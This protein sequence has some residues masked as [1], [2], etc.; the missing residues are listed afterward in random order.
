MAAGN[1]YGLMWVVVAR[2]AIWL[3]GDK[4]VKYTLYA[5]V[6]VLV[7]TF[8]EAAAATTAIMGQSWGQWWLAGVGGG[9][10]ATTATAPVSGNAPSGVPVPTIAPLTGIGLDRVT[11]M[12]ANA[13]TWLGTPYH[14]G[15]CTRKGVD[16]SCFVMNVLATIGIQA[17]RVTTAQVRWVRP[18]TRAELQPG[19]LVFFNDTC[20][21]CGPNPTHVGMFIG[22]GKMIN[23]G[24][25]VQIGPAFTSHYAGGGRPIGL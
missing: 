9:A 1:G 13:M 24:D 25:P 12:L 11:T 6:G 4:I 17:P 16:C 22:D 19:D 20:S 10:S 2:V 7:F 23:A 15:G 3:F 18:V 14:W 8:V 5:V 21:D